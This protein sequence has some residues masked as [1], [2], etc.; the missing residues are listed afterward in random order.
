[1]P[2]AHSVVHINLAPVPAVLLAMV[3][4]QSGAALA[5]GMFPA[6]GPI[7]A[8]ALRIVLSALI[9]LAVFRP[10]FR[11][12][13][14]SQW[15]TVIPFGMALAIMNMSFYLAIA[16]I[17][18]GLAVALEFTGPL[19]VAVLGSRQVKDFMWVLLAAA[20]IVLLTPWG[21][22]HNINAAGAMLAL[23]AGACWAIYIVLGRRVYHLFPGGTGVAA[24]MLF[25]A[26]TILPIVLAGKSLARVNANLLWQGLAVAVL[27]SALPYSLE[28]IGLRAM[29]ARTFGILMSMEP[30]VAA[31]CGMLFLRERLNAPE[32][33]AI[34][35]VIAASAGTTLTGEKGGVPLDA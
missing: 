21:G 14:R 20:G 12:L 5:T 29:P 2:S 34:A 17:P 8:V 6:V 24:G 13:T 35:L 22:S 30:A 9:L 32:W 1:M 7:G 27:S 4:V 16:R 33:L 15:V 11:S 3:S 18:L 23:V 26:L 19:T 25:A 31:L 28:M 10:P